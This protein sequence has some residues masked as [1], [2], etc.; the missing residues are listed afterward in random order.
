MKIFI[1]L[2]AYIILFIFFLIF[3]S[4]CFIKNFEYIKCNY[5]SYGNNRN[6]KY[7]LVV[8]GIFKNEEDYLEEWINH[9]LNQ[10]FDHIYLYNNDPDFHK[11]NYLDNYKDKITVIPWANKKSIGK[12]SIQRQ[13]YTDCIK[14]HSK[15]YQWILLADIDE[16]IKSTDKNKK[17]VDIIEKLDTKKIK[18]VRIPR[19]NF[20]NSGHIEKP[21]G[22]VVDNYNR[23]E[24]ECSSF[25]TLANIRFVDIGRKFLTVHDFPYNCHKG[26]IIN[27]TLSTNS[28]KCS[29]NFKNKI[30]LVINHYY[31]KSYEEYK[32]RCKMW[33]DKP[34][35][36]PGRRKV[37]DDYGQFMEKNKNMNE[38]EE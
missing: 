6:K 24:K 35:N 19:F 8:V 23:R 7:K 37:C 17:V 25:K 4:Y 29:P 20:G 9:Y 16:F 21:F 11:Y 2:I 31:T 22:N 12:F 18:S 34:V 5:L 33:Q 15:D 1:I 14:N 26:K 10:G 27:K 13:A 36:F 38:V 3:A 28:R 32:K 30:P